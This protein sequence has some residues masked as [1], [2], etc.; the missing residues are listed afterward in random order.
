LKLTGQTSHIWRPAIRYVDILRS[1]PLAG[2]SGSSTQLIFWNELLLLPLNNHSRKENLSVSTS[3]SCCKK[4]AEQL[5]IP[6]PKDGP[7]SS[8]DLAEGRGRVCSSMAEAK[9]GW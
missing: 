9:A 7:V 3:Q 4:F 1:V 6:T 2:T 5:T 8:E